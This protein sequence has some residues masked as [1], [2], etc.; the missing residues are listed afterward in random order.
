MAVNSEIRLHHFCIGTVKVNDFLR[1]CNMFS[2][3][4]ITYCVAAGFLSGILG[5]LSYTYSLKYFK[6]TIFLELT[7]VM[8]SNFCINNPMDYRYFTCTI[9]Y[10]I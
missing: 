7:A 6:I 4:F 2:M 9:I 5:L 10:G 1:I 3:K 8:N